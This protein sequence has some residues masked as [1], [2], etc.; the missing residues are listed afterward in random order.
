MGVI[1]RL[2][3]QVDELIIKPLGE[4]NRRNT[5]TKALSDATAQPPPNHERVER[6][7]FE[8][9]ENEPRSDLPVWLL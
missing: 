2:D 5:E 9:K 3:D 4:R 1:G 6:T 7:K 8:D